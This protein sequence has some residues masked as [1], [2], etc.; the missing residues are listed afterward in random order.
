M[1]LGE[2][3]EIRTYFL[4][5]CASIAVTL[6]WRVLMIRLQR[7]EGA[8]AGDLAM[9]GICLAVFVNLHYFA[10]LL[11]GILTLGLIASLRDRRAIS[12]ALVSFAAAVPALILLSAQLVHMDTR[13]VAWILTGR[14]DAVFALG[15]NVW[16]ASGQN[17]FA[18]ACAVVALLFLA[19][20]RSQWRA[21]RHD[22]I[23]LGLILVYCAA[24]VV[25][26]AIRPV[27]ID[28]YL[29]AV[30]GA[31]A[32]LIAAVA[33][34]PRLP[35][36][37]VV[38]ICLFAMLV[39]F[40]GWHSGQFNTPGWSESARFV[41]DKAAACPD[42]RVLIQPDLSGDDLG[43]YLATLRVGHHYYAERMGFT[44]EDA[45]L[46]RDITPAGPC[47][48][49]L[50]AE[51]KATPGHVGATEALTNVGLKA[52]RPAEAYRVGTATVIIVSPPG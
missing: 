35:A 5:F 6:V 31:I 8:G 45:P 2:L 20:D 42:T 7:G 15:D 26:N 36:W 33:A 25:A 41:A 43:A 14:V 52:G 27:I 18:L 21:S 10:T 50:W 30:G 32:V 22:L 13:I 39:Q 19:G 40:R 46:S 47:P 49:I 38:A 4:L 23:L 51:D 1:F 17:V 34:H 16:S 12:I 24:L 48:T 28:R 44:I 29:V 9:W 37:S 3:A 11:G